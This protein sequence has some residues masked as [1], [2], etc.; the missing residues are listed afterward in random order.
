MLFFAT[1]KNRI[2]FLGLYFG[3]GIPKKREERRKAE[4]NGKKPEYFPV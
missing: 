2:F 3:I 1:T 4:K